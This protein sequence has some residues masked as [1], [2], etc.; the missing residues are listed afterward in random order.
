MGS[1]TRYPFNKLAFLLLGVFLLFPKVKDKIEIRAKYILYSEDHKYLY[2][3]GAVEVKIGKEKIKTETLYY[4]VRRREGVAL[5]NTSFRGNSFHLMI[6]KIE[7]ERLKWRG[8]RFG[9][10]LESFGK[11]LPLPKL[12][13]PQ[14]LMKAALYFEAKKVLIDKY[15][16]VK[17]WQVQPYVLGAPS[18]PLPS[19]VLDLG[20]PPP[21][22]HLRPG[23]FRFTREEGAIA[24][25]ALDIKEKIYDGS[26]ELKYFE[27]ELFKIP[28][29]PR[30]I[31]FYGYGSLRKRGKPSLLDNSIFYT[32]EGKYL[33]F[34]L[35][36]SR[37]GKVFSFFLQNRLSSRQYEKPHYWLSTALRFQKYRWFQPE[38]SLGWDY[39]NSYTLTLNT[40][41]TPAKNLNL[42]LSWSRN[43]QET[44][45][46][47]T[48]TET[49]SLHLSYSPS[50]FNFSSSAT[51]SK[52][53]ME[54]TSRK[55]IS[56]NLN[57]RPFSLLMGSVSASVRTFFLFSE[58]PYGNGYEEKI[59]PGLRLSLSSYGLSLPLGFSLSPSLDFYQIWDKGKTS[60]TEVN[61]FIDLER[62][63][64]KFQLALEFNM[65]SRLKATGFWVEGYHNYFV[66]LG[67]RF[68][69]MASTLRATFFMNKELALER[70]NLNG[71]LGLIWG[72]R[73]RFFALY[74]S[75]TEKLSIFEGYLEKNF[76]NALKIQ[77]GYSLSYKKY[78]FRVIPL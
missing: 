21:K 78:F 63:I 74:N 64:W 24:G 55:D 46:V 13:L 43:N 71:D 60:W 56:L 22:T 49:S 69:N 30:G 5:G 77:V 32:S 75:F 8:L 45:Y 47:T 16:K 54:K 40:Y 44:S 67:L 42:N 66:N 29:T 25:V 33:D 52:D 23:S 57:L 36:T 15:G 12:I 58:F 37:E 50:I 65:N 35:S 53:L 7:K 76:R 9:K 73:L 72:I 11:D 34:S 51:F 3:S 28:G 39:K 26:Y 4:S 48:R 41:M 17:G 14:D 18:L 2:A 59:S 31:I 20:N 62:S 68:H 6:F 38:V 1:F 61:T 70:I 10:K 27:R 19:L